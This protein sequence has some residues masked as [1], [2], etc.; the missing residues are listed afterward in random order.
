MNKK[1]LV[2]IIVAIFITPFVLTR[3]SI[4]DILD[5][6]STGEIGDTI[7]GTTA[8][9]IGIVSILLLYLTLKEQIKFNHSQQQQSEEQAK[10]MREEQFKTTLFNL[11]QQQRDILH[12]L[13]AI[14]KGL[15]TSDVSRKIQS[16]IHGQEFFSMAV[17]ELTCLF[18]SMESDTYYSSYNEEEVGEMMETIY[19]SCYC[20]TNLPQ[21][22]EEEN[23]R[24]INDGKIMAYCAYMNNIFDIKK[25]DYNK[26]R[27]LT[28]V[29]EKSH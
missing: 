8:P 23:K 29:E 7:G 22:L 26:Y 11:L 17:F 5:F 25:E 12:S 1:I 9:I 3:S 6:S 10:I 4:L 16:K 15:S 14:F 24:K 27:S 2:I 18:R 13:Q 19:Q 21:E 28:S 20:G